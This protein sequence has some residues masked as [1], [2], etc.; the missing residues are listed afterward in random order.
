LLWE[1]ANS[2]RRTE[3]S[4]YSASSSGNPAR[5][6]ISSPVKVSCPLIGDFSFHPSIVLSRLPI[7]TKKPGDE[8][9]FC[10]FRYRSLI[11]KVIIPQ[12]VWAF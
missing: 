6:S 10:F 3:S 4:R 5:Y 11:Q 9:G 12:R 1:F 8:P 7:K 2:I